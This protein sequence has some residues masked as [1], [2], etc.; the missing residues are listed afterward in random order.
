L[1]VEY[2]TDLDSQPSIGKIIQIN[3]YVSM[4]SC[5]Y[6]IYKNGQ[7][8]APKLK[9]YLNHTGEAWENSTDILDES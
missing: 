3:D 5:S 9:A 1:N 6:W 2:L 7:G 4:P 8:I